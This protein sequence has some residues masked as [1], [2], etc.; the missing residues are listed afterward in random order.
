M[1]LAVCIEESKGNKGREEGAEALQLLADG[2]GWDS[3]NLKH[4]MTFETL[5]ME[6]ELKKAIVDDFH[7][8]DKFAMNRS[9]LVVEDIDCSFGLLGR[10]DF[11]ED[12]VGMSSKL[13]TNQ[14]GRMDLHIHMSYLTT[15]GFG[16]LGYNSEELLRGEDADVALEGVAKLLEQKDMQDNEAKAE[17]G[18]GTVES[19]GDNKMQKI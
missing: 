7:R 6:P 9:I 3:I 19:L 8:F 15:K 4:P 2:H 18:N 11:P 1:L 12:E 13:D 5:A 14:P 17:G 10:G 16:V